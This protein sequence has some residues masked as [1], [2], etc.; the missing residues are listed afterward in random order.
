MCCLFVG[1][2]VKSKLQN[3][4]ETSSW[5]VTCSVWCVTAAVAVAGDGDVA[6]ANVVADAEVVVVAC[7]VD[8]FGFVLRPAAHGG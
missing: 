5:G 6:C 4:A 8:V 3:F 7:D 1:F 2:R